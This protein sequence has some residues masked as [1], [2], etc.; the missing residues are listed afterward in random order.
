[1]PETK[2]QVTEINQLFNDFKEINE[3]KDAE[4]KKL[5]EESGETKEYIEKLENRIDELDV[6]LQRPESGIETFSKADEEAEVKKEAWLNYLRKGYDQL[7]DIE[8]K[9]MIAS[10]DTTGGFLTSPEKIQEIIKNIVEMSPV[11]QVARVRTTSKNSVHIPKRTGNIT[12]GYWV[13][14]IGTRQDLGSITY[15]MEEIPAHELGGY[16][17]VSQHNLDDS[18]YNLEQEIYSEIAEQY[19]VTEGTSFISGSGVNQPEGLLTNGDVGEVANGHATALQADALID[20]IYEVK[21]PYVANSN[22]MMERATIKAVRKL[23]DGNGDY[24]W[25]PALGVGRPS[26]ILE[27]P[28]VE[29]TDMPTI[30]ANAYPILFGDFRQAYMIIDREAIAFTRDVT[31]QNLKRVVRILGFKRL[32]GQ[33][34]KPEAIKK[35]K[36]ATSV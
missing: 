9:T 29:A 23:K 27:R 20:L 35:L 1:M 6:K 25:T 17:D 8:K 19:A 24:L 34:I 10:N 22:F 15:G 13:Q 30:G 11:R 18:D 33:V 31:T 12:G 16:V 5:G 26:L 28:Y 7:S 3:R 14:E 4:I 32:G 2:N 21:N 36:I